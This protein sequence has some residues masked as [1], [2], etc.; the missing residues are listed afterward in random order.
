MSKKNLEATYQQ[1]AEPTLEKLIKQQKVSAIDNLEEISKLWPLADEPGDLFDFIM[2][3]RQ[4]R[5]GKDKD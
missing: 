4:E 1:Q 2:E 3:A 5:R